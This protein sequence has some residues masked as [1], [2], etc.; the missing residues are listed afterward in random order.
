MISVTEESGLYQSQFASL[1]KSLNAEP[2][3]LVGVRKAAMD[4]FSILGFPTTSEEE[5]RFTNVAP[6]SRIPFKPA[7]S[8]SP[9]LGVDRVPEEFVFGSWPGPEIVFVNGRFSQKLSSLQGHRSP[10]Q[11]EN[12][13]AL[14]VSKPDLLS[15]HLSRHAGYDEHAFVAL[16]TAFFRDGSVIRIPKDTVAEEPVHV[17]YLS[18]AHEEPAVS[19]PRNLILAESNTQARILESYAGQDSLYMTNA[20]TEIFLDENAIVDHYRLQR[21]GIRAFH[22]S[23]LQAHIS[24]DSNFSTHSISLG[25]ALVRNDVNVVLDGE[26]AEAVLNGLYLGRGQQHI[27]NHTRIDH[28]KAHCSSRE[29][30]KG[31][32]DER[33]RGVF[34]GRIIVRQG[35]QKTDSKQTNKNLLLSDEA[36]ANTNPQLEIYADDVKCT[37]GAT[38][39]QLSSEAIFYLR[40]RGIG[41][42]SARHLLT[43]AFASD[44]TNRIKIASVREG[45]ERLL[46]SNLP[47][48]GELETPHERPD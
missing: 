21:E 46:F 12:L 37:H 15:T 16:N 36:L 31:I 39:G 3:W 18:T 24:R 47:G 28:A 5:W 44:L 20:V 23:T 7:S 6:I 34:S 32:L 13:G 41:L 33:A 40:S 17:L 27:D 2:S 4:R 25:G 42:E 10:I 35:A 1:E 30:Y 48:T 45:L 14:L 19:Y 29:L 8:L 9:R 22:V 38:V 26:G 43:Y 11:I